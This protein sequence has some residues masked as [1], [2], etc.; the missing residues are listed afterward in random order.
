[1]TVIGC[2]RAGCENQYADNP[3]GVMRYTGK[4]TELDGRQVEMVK[5]YCSQLCCDADRQ[6]T[7]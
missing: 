2:D 6:R 4:W 3:R 7:A 1:M 5:L